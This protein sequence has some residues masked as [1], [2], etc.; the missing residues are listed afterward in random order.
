MKRIF[1]IILSAII[2]TGCTT[3]EDI[4]LD[5]TV[6][7]LDING[8]LF[9]QCDTNKVLV[10]LTGMG[11]PTPVKNATVELRVNGNLCETKTASDSLQGKYYGLKTIINPD[12]H[13]RVDVYYGNQHAYA[14]DVCPAAPKNLEAA[15]EYEENYAYRDGYDEFQID[16]LYKVTMSFTDAD[17]SKE[18]YYRVS[19]DKH[20]GYEGMVEKVERKTVYV[21]DKE[22]PEFSYSYSYDTVYYCH[23][24][25]HLHRSGIADLANYITTYENNP[26]L[27]PEERIYDSYFWDDVCNYF[28]IFKNTGFAGGNCTMTFHEDVDFADYNH[29]K[30]YDS[31]GRR[32]RYRRYDD[33]LPT[34]PS[35]YKYSTDEELDDIPTYFYYE[36]VSVESYSAQGY[37]LLQ[38]LNSYISGQYSISE[39]TG[40]VKMYSNVSGGTGYIAAASRITKVVKVID[41][42]Q[43]EPIKEEEEEE[44]E[45]E[46]SYWK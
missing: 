8:F 2:F 1:S 6:G 40:S 21:E 9:S 27:R 5:E 11:N 19:L 4:T 39:L 26:E 28:R 22:N 30:N 38:T 15:V 46:Y 36:T 12:D 42:Y 3:Y 20:Y 32:V 17:G 34:P 24:I 43:P 33:K 31:D 41:G 7:I 35:E 14:E 44:D 45:N 16:D 13:I 37:E 23:G 10:T 25:K 18:N 29:I